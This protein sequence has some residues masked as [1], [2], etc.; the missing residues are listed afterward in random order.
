VR[1][2]VFIILI[3]LGAPACDATANAGGERDQVSEETAAIESEPEPESASEPDAD[4]ASCQDPPRGMVCVPGGSAIIGANDQTAVEKP[5]H[6]VQ[7][8]TFYIDKHEV[9][10]AEYKKCERAG[11]CKRRTGMPGS[12]R[13]YLKPDLPAIPI[14]WRMA[15]DYCLWTGKRLPTEAEWEKVARGGDEARTFPWGDD[16]ATCDKAAYKGCP[17]DKTHPVGSYPV[18]PYG[19]FDMAGNG[20]EWVQD[21]ATDCY[22]GCDD[23]CGDACAGLDPTGPCDGLRRCKGR[24]QRLL[25]GGSW[26]WPPEQMRGSFRRAQRQVSGLH[27]FSFRCASSMSQ[28]TTWPSLAVTDPRAELAD[29]E[30]PTAEELALFRDV[31]NDEDIMKIKPC[32]N[33]GTANL[34]CR[35]PMSYIKSNESAQWVWRPYIE[36]LGGG[37]VGLGADQGYSFIAAARSR[38]AWIFDYDPQVV[39]IHT[40]LHILIARAETPVEMVD[41]FKSRNF[42]QTRQWIR[43]A[44]AEDEDEQ[45]AVDE[46]Y[47]TLRK[48]LHFHYHKQMQA[49]RVARNFGWLRYPKNYD[50]VRKM[51]AQGRI[52]VVKG[53]MLNDKALP[54]IAEAARALGVPM[55]IYYPS[56]APEQWQLVPQYRANVAGFPFDEQS[57]VLSTLISESYRRDDESPSYWHYV[58]HG[59]LDH[60]RKIQ[61]E[62]YKNVNQF[63]Q[64]KLATDREMLSVIRMPARTETEQ[65][66]ADARQPE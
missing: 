46:L 10:N 50:Y 6:E 63:T 58:V 32:R 51:L 56:N 66:T 29:P 62:S 34:D 15:H 33:E 60:Q 49:K 20:Y 48:K 38:W 17:P 24:N 47:R 35:D 53:N 14:Q 64:E 39:R 54:Q 59:G 65:S 8:S 13:A 30:P 23:A 25:K 2:G 42:K 43:E 31:D 12:Y 36:N 21:W 9:T 19:V 44:L 37:Y 22:D 40:L 52:F 3:G 18:G 27:R 28:L 61:I 16:P 11:V 55:R 41:A 1:M 5:R 45:K 26:Y 7:L 4:F 57:V